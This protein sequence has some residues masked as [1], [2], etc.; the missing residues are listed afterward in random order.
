[1]SGCWDVVVVGAF[2]D[3]IF[4]SLAWH[5]RDLRCCM[6][7]RCCFTVCLFV[8]LWTHIR[9]CPATEI[10][11]YGLNSHALSQGLYPG[12]DKTN[13]DQAKEDDLPY[14]TVCHRAT[15]CQMWHQHW[16]VYL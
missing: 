16:Y 1:M 9:P 15:G 8:G 4:G 3:I 11:D 13:A 14:A 7:S 2:L 10:C 12:P 6:T 5:S